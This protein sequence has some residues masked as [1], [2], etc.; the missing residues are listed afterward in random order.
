MIRVLLAIIAG[1]VVAVLVV[2]LIQYIGHNVYPIPEDL[3]PADQEFM[4]QYIASLPWGSLAFVIASYALATL[5]G[6]WVAAAVAGERPMVM[7]SIV[8]LLVMAGAIT[9][10]MSIPHPPWF[11]AASVVAVIAAA[12]IAGTIESNRGSARRSL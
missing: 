9:T 10:V 2:M 5:A 1:A 3:D 8:G 12:I 4:R 11:T 7:A 6:G